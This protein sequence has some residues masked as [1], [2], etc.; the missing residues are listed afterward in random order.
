MFLHSVIQTIRRHKLLTPGERILVGVSGGAD[1]VAL[2]WALRELSST[3]RLRLVMAHLN[4]GIRGASAAADAAFVAKLARRWKLPL[5]LGRVNVPLLARRQGLSLEM[6]GRKAR[7]NFFAKAA[8]RYRCAAIATAHT[9]DDQAETILL[10]LARGTGAAGLAGIPYSGAHG[11]L[12]VIRPLRDVDRKS[13]ERFLRRRRLAWRED[14]TNADPAFLRNRVRH[15]ILPLLAERLNPGI[16]SALLRT[17]EIL[18]GENEW[19]A[20]LTERLLAECRERETCLN[21]KRLAQFPVAARRRVLRR[22]L[23]ECN[24][25]AATRDF[26]TIE[27]LD[28]LVKVRH[29]GRAACHA[30]RVVTLPGGWLVRRDGDKLA[31]D[32]LGSRA[33]PPATLCARPQH[34]AQRCGQVALRAGEGVDSS[35]GHGLT[36]AATR[37]NHRLWRHNSRG[38]TVL[39]FSV[40]LAVPGHTQ[41]AEQGVRITARIGPG[42]VKERALAVGELPARASLSLRAWRRRR[43]KARSWRSGDRMRPLGL[44]GSKKLQDIFT[45][46]KLPLGLRHRLPIIECGGEIIWIPGFRIAQGWAVRPDERAALQLAV[47]P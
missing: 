32:D 11:G 5:A 40:R 17:S 44:K 33:R 1:S 26:E 6:A 9:A 7:Y 14:A 35:G 8:R 3:W 46:G 12:R 20:T 2:A 34:F 4:H 45:D 13:I 10:N 18:A 16:R 41:L 22:W 21:A 29:S 28:N 47:E 24:L 30:L 39:P 27:R 43:L 36:P 23:E 19:L 25:E 42:I 37:K 38:E 31:L 15:E